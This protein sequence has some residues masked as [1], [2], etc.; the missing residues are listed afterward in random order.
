VRDPSRAV[1]EVTV[2]RRGARLEDGKIVQP[3]PPAFESYRAHPPAVLSPCP[4]T[5]PA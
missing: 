5:R 1:R 4:R 3:G 2:Y